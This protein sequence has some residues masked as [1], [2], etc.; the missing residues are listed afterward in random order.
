M[1]WMVSILCLLVGATLG[2]LL[3]ERRTASLRVEAGL[4]TQRLADQQ[5]IIDQT[6]TRLRDAFASASSEALTRNSEAFLGLAQQSFATLAAQATGSLDERKAQIDGMLK[7]MQEL[8]AQYQLR[9]G[10]IEQSRTRAYGDLRQMLGEVASTQQK[11]ATQTTQL[12]GALRRPQARGQWGEMTLRRLV[13]LSGMSQHC[14]FVEQFSVNSEGGRLR[15]DMIINLPADRQIIIDCK[16]VLDAYLDAST[17]TDEEQRLGF[18]KRHSQQLRSRAMELG[19]KSYFSQFKRS[20]E[21][22]ILFLP[23]EAFLYAAIEQDGKLVEDCME[24]SVILATP[25]TLLALLKAVAFGWRQEQITQNAEEIR[26][27]GVELYDRIN[28]LTTHLAKLGGSLEGSVQA[29]NS[30]LASMESR[31]LVTARKIAELGARS[32]KQMA[33]VEPIDV[34][35]R[36]IAAALAAPSDSHVH[37]P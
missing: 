22:V 19:A 5:K 20:P 34:H 7:P 18:L 4:A 25:T 11:L 9:L 35:P 21:F 28:T 26:K 31:V 17:A 3:A 29:Y 12:A 10:E 13:E 27:L 30:M 23:G 6:E 36:A 32:E 2:W 1:I 24:R 14:D 37:Q 16:A 15:P 33:E 8:L